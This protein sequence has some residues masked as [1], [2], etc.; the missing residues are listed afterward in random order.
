MTHIFPTA[1]RKLGRCEGGWSCS[2]QQPE[3]RV[4]YRTPRASRSF[5]FS[6]R[7]ALGLASRTPIRHSPGVGALRRVTGRP[8]APWRRRVPSALRHGQ[9]AQLRLLLLLGASSHVPLSPELQVHCCYCVSEKP[10]AEVECER[11]P[12]I[13]LPALRLRPPTPGSDQS[14]FTVGLSSW[15]SSTSGS[16]LPSHQDCDSHPLP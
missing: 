3:D 13:G 12:R 9:R 14:L 4:S 5:M 6:R 8:P 7:L 15:P 16:V 2:W 11:G 1:A 10:P